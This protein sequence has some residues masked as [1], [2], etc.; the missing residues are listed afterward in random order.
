MQGLD[1]YCY[2]KFTWTT[3]TKPLDDESDVISSESVEYL[4]QQR[5]VNINPVAL[6]QFKQ[7]TFHVYVLKVV[8]YP[9]SWKNMTGCSVIVTEWRMRMV[10]HNTTVGRKK[11]VQTSVQLEFS[12]SDRR[13]HARRSR[14]F[15]AQPSQR[16]ATDKLNM[17]DGYCI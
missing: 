11:L 10:G 15:G 6:L 5:Y 14:R 12:H 3:V 4:P 9:H 1:V 8:A 2:N 13:R 16:R 7:F 17:G